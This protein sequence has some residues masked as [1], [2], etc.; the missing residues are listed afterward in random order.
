MV[1]TYELSPLIWFDSI[2]IDK[3]S[4]QN[5]ICTGLQAGSLSSRAISHLHVTKENYLNWLLTE[6]KVAA[7]LG[8]G[9][10]CL[11]GLMAF[12]A[13]GF[14]YEFGFVIFIANFTCVLTS[15]LT[16][17]LAPLVFTF[18][19]HRDAGKWGSLLGTAMQDIVG[20]FAMIIMSIHLLEMRGPVEVDPNDMCGFVQ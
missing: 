16:G 7:I 14:D 5:F 19:F 3:S 17:T 8:F 13:S 1:S 20:A 15:G 6:I 11:I 2:S 18:I 4:T 12:Q 10:G 9:I